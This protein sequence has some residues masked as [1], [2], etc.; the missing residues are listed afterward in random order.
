MFCHC[1][2]YLDIS[3]WNLRQ[4]SNLFRFFSRL[5]AKQIIMVGNEIGRLP[6]QFGD[7]SKV[8]NA[9]LNNGDFQYDNGKMFYNKFKSVVSYQTSQI[10]IF[11]MGSVENAEKLTIYDSIDSDV[12]T[13][14][15]EYSLASLIYYAMKEGACSE[16]SSRMTAMDNSSKNA[17]EI[18]RREIVSLANRMSMRVF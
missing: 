11:S 17:G 10:P 12:L 4:K 3:I 9:I 7:A 13:S 15:T 18:A 6:P 14:Y 1:H 16:Q 2:I 5:F 8:A